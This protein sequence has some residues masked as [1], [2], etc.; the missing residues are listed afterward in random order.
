M[1]G[2]DGTVT[3]K[4]TIRTPVRC[5][6][7]AGSWSGTDAAR[8]GRTRRPPA[9][10]AQSAGG[11]GDGVGT[12]ATRGHWII[13]ESK[14]LNNT[15]DGLDL[16]Y[17][18]PG[19]SIEIRRTLAR[20]NAGNQIKTAGPVLVENSVIVGSCGFHQGKPSTRRDACGPSAVPSLAI[21]CRRGAAFRREG[22]CRSLPVTSS[23]AWKVR[24]W[25]LAP[26]SCGPRSSIRAARA[27]DGDRGSAPARRSSLT[28]PSGRRLAC[29]LG[30]IRDARVRAP[31]KRVDEI[32]AGSRVLS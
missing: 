5:D 24:R 12:G 27:T 2:P 14:F 3:S 4:G 7:P 29:H 11:Y 31:R 1:D 17:A 22:K 16:L 32:V 23:S 20:G 15:S 26:R 8:A 13:E 28:L 18:K 25:T 19:S 30:Q 21:T 9:C 6:S 10:W